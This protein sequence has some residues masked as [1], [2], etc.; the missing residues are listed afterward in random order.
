MIGIC[1]INRLRRVRDMGISKPMTAAKKGF[2]LKL[3]RLNGNLIQDSPRYYSYC[4]WIE[5][6]EQS[7]LY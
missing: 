3:T 1:L 4:Y 7:H 2:S 6:P 5:N